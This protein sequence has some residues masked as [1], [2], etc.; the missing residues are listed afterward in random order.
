MNHFICI[1]SNGGYLGRVCWTNSN[2]P[3]NDG[4]WGGVSWMPVTILGAW[5]GSIPIVRRLIR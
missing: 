3:G 2:A 1:T 4:P 5:S